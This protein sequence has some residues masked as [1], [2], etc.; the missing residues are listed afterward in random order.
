LF[1][2]APF[3]LL[4]LLT[5]PDD[6]TAF[7]RRQLSDVFFSEG[8]ALADL[9]RDG[10]GDVVAG[11]YWY[12]GPDFSQRRELYTPLAFDP[13]EYSDHFF[14]YPHDVDGDGWTDVLVVGFPGQAANWYR[15]PGHPA[16]A[17]TKHWERHLAHPGIDNESPAFTDLTGDGR[18]EL[19]FHSGGRFGWAEPDRADPT[20]PWRFHSLSSDLGLGR[21]QHGL[22]VGDVNSDGRNDVLW[23]DGWFEQPED[24][25]GDPNWRFHPVS[26]GARRGGA[27][28]FVDDFDG[29]GDA[30]VVT[31]LDAH[32]WGLAWY[33]QVAAER[34]EP[35][36]L[37][38]LIMDARPADNSHGLAVAELHAL[39][40]VDV[41]GDGLSDIVTGNRY[42]S[43]GP[44][45]TLDPGAPAALV[46]FRCK[47]DPEGVTWEPRMIDD[48]S[49]VGT[50]LSVG[51]VNAD[52]LLDVV[53][54]NKQGA[55]LFTQRNALATPAY[56]H[57]PA[58]SAPIGVRPLGH[59]GR[60]LNLG[61]ETGDLTDWLVQGEA[62]VGQPVRGDTV[63]ARGR[64]TSRHAGEYWIGGYEL[65]EDGPQGSLRSV[66]FSVTHP[67]AS[68]LV[69]GGGHAATRVELLAADDDRVLFKSSAGNFES[70]QRV[71]VDL[72]GLLGERIAVQIVD[73]QSGG[74]GHINYDDFLFHATRPEFTRPSG[75]PLL[76]PPDPVVHA[77]LRPQEAVAAMTVPAGFAVDLIAAEPG[78]H[79]PIALSID[80]KGRLW[81]AEAHSYPVRLPDGQGKDRILV[82]EDRD[83][84]GSFETTTVFA[85]DLNLVSGLA[86]GHGGVW[87]GAAPWLLFFPD[88]DDDLVPD[89]EAQILLDGW[90]WQDTHETL[91]SFTWGPDG[92][93]YGCHGVFTH[94]RVG[95]PGTPDDER[96]PINA[97][98]WRYHPTQH[99]FEVFAEGT[100]NPWGVAFDAQGQAFLT[101]CVIPHLYHAVQ[102]GRYLRQA[103]QHFGDHIYADIDTIA[104]HRHYLG[105]TPHAG[106]LRSASVGGGHAHCGAMIY[107]GNA[108]PERWRGSLFMNNVHGNRINVDRLQ[109]SGS[110]YVGLHDDDFLLANDSWFRGIA[111][112]QGPD[113]AV[114]LIDWYDQRACH[115]KD[116]D[117]WDRT[118]GRLYR[119]RYG[120]HTAWLGDL[121]DANDAELVEL[122][123]QDDVWFV[124]QARLLL[125]ERAAANTGS[126]WSIHALL[127]AFLASTADGVQRLN[128]L[129]SLHATGGLD[130]ATQLQMLSDPDEFLRAWAIQLGAEDGTPP[131]LVAQHWW[132]LSRSDP[133][134]VVR[135]YLASALQR[136]PVDEPL[137]FSLAERLS[138]H[139]EDEHDAN[140]PLL[141]WYG[142]EPLVSV[143]VQR[144]LA[145][146]LATPLAQLE[147]FIVRRIATESRHHEMLSRVILGKLDA[148]HAALW[149]E[150]WSRAL[151]LAGDAPMP[152]WWP[153]LAT[154]LRS[155]DDSA[156]RDV[157]LWMA[158]AYNDPGATPELMALLGD[159]AADMQRRQDALAALARTGDVAALQVLS[160]VLAEPELCG[161]ALRALAR[162]DHPSVPGLILSH[163]DSFDTAQR[164]DA[165]STLA[166]RPRAARALLVAVEDGRVDSTD[167]SAFVLRQLSSHDDATI[168]ALIARAVGVVGE[169]SADKQALIAAWKLRYTPEYLGAA[170]L[171]HGRA[172]FARTCQQCHMLFDV[173]GNVGPEITG[174]NR[175]DL[176]YLLTTILDPNAVIGLDYQATTVWTTDG[177]VL[178][179]I[180]R[181]ETAQGLELVTE[182]ESI[183]VP[184]GEIDERRLSEV[185]TMAEGLLTG[186]PLDDARDLIAYLQSPT[187]VPQAASADRPIELFNGRDLTGW[188]GDPAVWSVREK[189]I[190]G[191]TTGLK[192]NSF[193]RSDYLLG[194][195]RLSCEVQLVDDAGNSGIQFRSRELDGGDVSGYQ[196]DIGKGWWGKLYE[197]HGREQLAEPTGASPVRPGQWNHYEIEAIG[198]RIRTA[199]NGTLCIDLDDPDGERRGILALQVHSGGPTEVRFRNFELELLSDG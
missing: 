140:I 191:R 131:Q 157:V 123:G 72:S 33:E 185:S 49:G 35:T 58:P 102:G 70:M 1:V 145:L 2:T 88:R 169:P 163:Y 112:R 147:R 95:K 153:A 156:L 8:A 79:Q 86:V 161:P 94:S 100:S 119:V 15:N 115:W 186:L 61:L 10:H 183:V 139:A 114:Y 13:L 199:I 168:D 6:D 154:M 17:D 73:E 9:D 177:R 174:A 144:A 104:D 99:R 51:D 167:L 85:D 155:S 113:G 133:S 165:I 20:A 81:V 46:W 98:L 50:Q 159:R 141:L 101:A 198:S 80:A 91:N 36:F 120:E 45:G 148:A 173:G 19:V 107:Q 125:A 196:A 7:E 16:A 97:G 142:I 31:S 135:R 24:L 42:W 54:G 29:D 43:H 179:G 68:F 44:G 18:P 38:H 12:R 124:R 188:T 96:T 28:M 84:D 67:F 103:G 55:F 5:P 64:E 37:E 108:F 25:S 78:L 170:D 48:D 65:L 22:G 14:T 187:Q 194:D 4:A 41:D 127:Q 132:Q 137:R 87:V 92:W 151:V 23:R 34:G 47:R 77:G 143:D 158:A 60:I 162:I 126:S 184:L 134:P 197:E 74:W 172:V 175:G 111:L 176:D 59:D 27:Q 128:A 150:E 83:G 178:S 89:G 69:G 180:V 122:H 164:R 149:L 181:N 121:R 152:P 30:D 66:P 190:V 57:V 32:G 26:F 171:S 116:P 195:F 62:F 189:A 52:G 110:G 56:Q 182:N 160:D 166:T 53:I 106:N 129:W 76:L 3:T 75:L 82:L 93:L 117:V 63:S 40:L 138:L 71:V 105:N 130:E 118:N 109:P 90:A 21:F 39:A 193:L 11:P 146:A 136:L 192:H